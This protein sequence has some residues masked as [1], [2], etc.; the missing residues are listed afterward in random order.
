VQLGVQLQIPLGLHAPASHVPHELPQPS[1]PH[2]LPAQLHGAHRLAWQKSPAVH[3]LFAQHASPVAP[4]AAPS[5]GA[6]ICPVAS[7]PV[8][9]GDA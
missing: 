6:S 9:G 2:I 3:T 7:V 4:H 8:S 5:D 1:V